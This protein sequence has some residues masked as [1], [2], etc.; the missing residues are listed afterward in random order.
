MKAVTLFREMFGLRAEQAVN[1]MAA[2]VL[3]KSFRVFSL[4]HG[5]GGSFSRDITDLDQRL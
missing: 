3:S 2:S 1:S 5:E 4:G